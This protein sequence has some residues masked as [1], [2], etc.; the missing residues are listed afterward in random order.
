MGGGSL[1]TLREILGHSSVQVTER[2]GH[3]KPDHFRKEDLLK[4]RVDFARPGGEVIELPARR[5]A[6]PAGHSSGTDAE[7]T[8]EEVAA[9]Q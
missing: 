5:V 6:G 8:H 1:A 3:L 9:S 7:E 2:Y 4:M